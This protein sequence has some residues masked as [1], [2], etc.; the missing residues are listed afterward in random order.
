M[1]VK[2]VTFFYRYWYQD[3]MVMRRSK[4]L[5]DIIIEKSNVEIDGEIGCDRLNSYDDTRMS[6]KGTEKEHCEGYIP[7][8]EG[9]FH[10]KYQS[11]T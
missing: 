1:Q 5:I 8:L 10:C 7:A 6:W 3:V 11:M 2:N 9:A 4:N